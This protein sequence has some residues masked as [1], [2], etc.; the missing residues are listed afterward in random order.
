VTDRRIVARRY[1]EWFRNSLPATVQAYRDREE[2]LDVVE[3]FLY[4]EIDGS[5]TGADEGGGS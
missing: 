5:R 4:E 1:G 3:E 2:F